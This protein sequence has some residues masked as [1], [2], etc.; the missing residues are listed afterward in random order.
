[1]KR[2]YFLIL[3]LFA[4]LGS[5]AEDSIPDQSSE[6]INPDHG[7]ID[8]DFVLPDLDL[9][10]HGLHRIELSLA[11]TI[12][13]LYRGDIFTAANVTDM[14][15]NYRFNLLPDRYYFQAGII[16]TCQGDS[17]LRAGFPGGPYS[18]WWT[19]GWIDIEKGKMFSR[20]I[21]FK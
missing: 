13:S 12:D 9:P 2:N 4:L 7:S 8:F 20:K 15:Q 21:V 3:V 6:S 16:C 10:E 18:Q 1:M 14:K 11:R 19:S 5:C 17:C